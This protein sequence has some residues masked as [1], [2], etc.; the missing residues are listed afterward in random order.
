MTRPKLW[1][2][3]VRDLRSHCPTRKPVKVYVVRMAAGEWGEWRQ[4][5]ATHAIEISSTLFRLK[6]DPDLCMARETLVHEW[7]HALCSEAG[8]L[9]ESNDHTARW[10]LCYAEAYNAVFDR[11]ERS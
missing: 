1:R 7:A 4:R 11:Y 9:R 5:K 6:E 8:H 2:R 10:G 3:A